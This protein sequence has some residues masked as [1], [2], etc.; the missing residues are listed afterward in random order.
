MSSLL[1]ILQHLGLD[2]FL[3]EVASVE[4]VGNEQKRSSNN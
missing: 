1:E 4:M 2:F 3:A